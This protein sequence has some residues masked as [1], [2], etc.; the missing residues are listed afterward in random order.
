V[1][2]AGTIAVGQTKPVTINGNV[3]KFSFIPE[4]NGNYRIYSTGDEDTVGAIFNSNGNMITSNDDGSGHNFMI[5]TDLT[6]GETYYI[7][8]TLYGYE[9]SGNFN[10]VVEE[11]YDDE[12]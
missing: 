2:D 7:H 1:F 10:L 11:M 8:T 4:N 3:A 6:G 9:N 5:N 12:P